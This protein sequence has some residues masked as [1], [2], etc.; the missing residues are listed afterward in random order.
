MSNAAK[1]M[2]SNPSLHVRIENGPVNETS[3]ELFRFCFGTPATA[4]NHIAV[5]LP[6]LDGQQSC[7]IWATDEPVTLAVQGA[8]KSA[9]SDSWLMLHLSADMRDSNISTLT[10]ELYTHLLTE[11]MRRGYADIVRTWNYMANINAGEGD[12]ECYRQFSV[13]RSIAFDNQGYKLNALP[14]ATA[15]GSQPGTP[16][17]ITLLAGKA[18]TPDAASTATINRRIENPRQMSAFAYPREYG[19]RS[20][21]FSR[22]VLVNES[23]LLV[24]GTAS[25]LGHRSMHGSELLDQARETVANI[26]A[27]LEAVAGQTGTKSSDNNSQLRVYLRH[28]DDCTG[29]LAGLSELLSTTDK[30]IVLLG[31]ICRDD[32]LLEVEAVYQLPDEF[33]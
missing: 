32:L 15:I 3:N 1:K 23:T 26:N 14:A 18:A 22:A 29:A 30:Y 20:P 2:L 31:D 16:L 33:T 17:A 8:L 9:A 7:E 13:G 25:I 4:D 10:N 27:L 6:Q 21:S 11:A 24:S 12:N 28:P 19:P 5:A